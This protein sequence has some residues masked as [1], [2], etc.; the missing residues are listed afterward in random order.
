VQIQDTSIADAA[1]E[2]MGEQIIETSGQQVPIPFEVPYNPD[3]IQEN[4]MYS[5]RA[6]IRDAEG[7]LLF[8]TDTVN[9][10]ITNGAPT[11]N[12]E[13]VLIQVGG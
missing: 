12:I 8:T 2:V 4:H 9:P 11:E 3:D 10:V 6:T 1:A 5:I 13:L 7:T